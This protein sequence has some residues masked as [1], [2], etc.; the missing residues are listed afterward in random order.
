MSLSMNLH[1]VDKWKS[2]RVDIYPV[3][4]GSCIVIGLDDKFTLNN[5]TIALHY[6]GEENREGFIQMVKEAFAN[7]TQREEEKK[8][9]RTNKI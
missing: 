4:R 9:G 6:G 5:V 8:D 1:P 2:I 7:L 3:D